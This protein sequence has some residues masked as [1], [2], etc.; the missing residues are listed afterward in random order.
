M[1]HVRIFLA[2]TF[3]GTLPCPLFEWPC[4]WMS[5][6]DS[7]HTTSVFWERLSLSNKIAIATRSITSLPAS[8]FLME[9]WHSANKGNVSWNQFPDPTQVIFNFFF[10][11]TITALDFVVTGGYMFIQCVPAGGQS[12]HSVVSRIL[13]VCAPLGVIILDCYVYSY[14][15]KP[16]ITLGNS[17]SANNGYLKNWNTP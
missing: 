14:E 12:Q 7:S 17:V 11:L 13:W 4:F 3:L 5:K 8:D 16:Y 1:P 15:D 2:A 10:G 6:E 9:R